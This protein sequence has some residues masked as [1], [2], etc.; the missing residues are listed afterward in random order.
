MNRKW[1]TIDQQPEILRVVFHEEEPLFLQLKFATQ[2]DFSDQPHFDLMTQRQ[3][4]LSGQSGDRQLAL[5]EP[6]CVS[7]AR[8]TAAEI[9]FALRIHLKIDVASGDWHGLANLSS[10]TING[11][12]IFTAGVQKSLLPA[13][14]LK[15]RNRRRGTLL[16]PEKGHR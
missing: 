16:P 6:P 5:S 10:R 11:A 3:I 1:H 14:N 2:A 7:L 4:E 15:Q 13:R 9:K 8:A 12:S